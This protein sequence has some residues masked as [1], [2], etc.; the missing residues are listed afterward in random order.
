MDDKTYKT[1]ET[2]KLHA[3]C[4]F[5]NGPRQRPKKLGRVKEAFSDSQRP[6]PTVSRKLKNQNEVAP[7]YHDKDYLT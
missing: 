5:K 2:G 7:A 1:G 6:V 4:T 3:S